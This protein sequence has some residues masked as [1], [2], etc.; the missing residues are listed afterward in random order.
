[1]KLKWY[2]FKKIVLKNKEKIR[3]DGGE[4]KRIEGKN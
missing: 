1:M 2:R 4:E 3:K